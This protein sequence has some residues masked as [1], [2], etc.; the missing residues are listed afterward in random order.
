[1]AWTFLQDAT[2]ASGDNSSTRTL[3]YP[4]NVQAGSL[5]VLAVATFG[6]PTAA[7]TITDTLGNTYVQAGS[8][9]ILASNA[10]LIFWCVSLSGGANT[11]SIT[12]VGPA[13]YL[14]LGIHEYAPPA[15]VVVVDAAVTATGT[16]TTPSCGSIP[17]NGA[18]ELCIA[19]S[20]Q[21][22]GTVATVSAGT[23]FTFRCLQTNGL[24]SEAL[25]TE[26]ALNVSSAQTGIMT[27]ASSV[28]WPAIG[29]SFKVAPTAD[30]HAWSGSPVLSYDEV[31]EEYTY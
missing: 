18:N 10:V 16:S 2:L 19:A 26:D 8:T 23:G 3:A 12:P 31:E 11:V 29:V 15:G 7:F 30:Y 5:L 21:G 6:S 25:Y 27:L 22:N 13:V 9:A 28:G 24:S 14:S 4:G 20:G 1:M 17:V